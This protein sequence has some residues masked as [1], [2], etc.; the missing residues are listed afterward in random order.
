M[1]RLDLELYAE[2]LARH[3]ERTA[4]DLADAR[5]REAWWE[6]EQAARPQLTAADVARL[7]GLGLL[8]APPVAAVLGRTVAERARDLTAIHRLQ[9]IVEAQRAARRQVVTGEIATSSPP[10]WS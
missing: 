4:D 5:L 3:A 10:S 7:E 6:L 1:D 8:I 9:A 2:R